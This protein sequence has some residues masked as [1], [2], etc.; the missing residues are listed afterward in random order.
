MRVL[1]WVVLVC[2]LLVPVAAAGAQGLGASGDIRGSVTD[3]AGAVLPG[4]TVTLTDAGRGITRTATTDAQGSYRFTAVPPASYDLRVEIS[5]FETQV[6]KGIVVTVNQTVVM[7]FSLK[8]SA[9]VTEVDV[10]AEAPPD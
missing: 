9:V 3:P 4:A 2:L 6:T 10:T 8:V 1:T 7:D 5:G